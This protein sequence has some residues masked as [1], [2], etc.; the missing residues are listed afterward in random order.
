MGRLGH[1]RGS[2][3]AEHG[4]GRSSARAPDAARAEEASA[5][6]R[7]FIRVMSILTLNLLT[8]ES[9]RPH[10]IV[11]RGR[12]PAPDQLGRG[13][14]GLPAWR[15][16]PA[17]LPPRRPRRARSGRRP[18][19]AGDP[20]GRRPCGPGR[21]LDH[22]ADVRGR[23][24]ALGLDAVDVDRHRLVCREIPLQLR[25]R[26][27]SAEIVGAAERRREPLARSARRRVPRPR[28]RGRRGG[29][30]RGPSADARRPIRT[31]T[32]RRKAA[33]SMP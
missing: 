29:P 6:A 14:G 2:A 1:G 5:V 13:L 25:Q 31:A 4:A 20:R 3:S 24:V 9:R 8:L 12:G 21:E 11:L 28:P 17:S 33:R 16:G 27:G 30:E 10:H 15:S 7:R 19:A 22:A 26:L 18:R 23:A 32:G